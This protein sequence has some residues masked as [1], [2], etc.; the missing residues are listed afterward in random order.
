MSDILQALAISG[1]ILLSV[2]VLIIIVSIIAVNRGAAAM[3][4]ATEP[5][6]PLEPTAHHEVTGAATAATAAAPAKAA[7]AAAVPAADE[8]NVLQILGFGVALFV[9]AVLGLF[10]LSLIEHM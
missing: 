3:G 4:H 10:A 7:K 5:H 6:H 9:L 1:G 8:I 2:V